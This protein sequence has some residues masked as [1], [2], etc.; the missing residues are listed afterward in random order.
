VQTL[1]HLIEKHVAP[2]SRT[3]SESWAVYLHLNELSYEHFSVTHKSTFKQSY[4][5]F[6]TGEIVVCTTNR[7]EG[8]WKISKDHFRRINGTN[9]ANFE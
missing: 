6:Q 8:A 1:I 3:F 2:G 7:I 4:R 5:N 9:T